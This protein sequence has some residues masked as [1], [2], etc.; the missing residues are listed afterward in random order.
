MK[1]ESY[2]DL[3]VWQRGID[4]V[5]RI[6]RLTATLPNEE[7]YGLSSQ[8]QRASVSIPANIAEGWAREHLGDYLRHLSF[9]KASLAEVETLLII[10]IN[11]EYIAA[12]RIDELQNDL[13]ILGKKLTTLHRKLKLKHPNA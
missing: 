7:R 2:K 9:A 3:E 13:A 1:I 11:L 10:C 6:Y 5:T 12:S 8:L 4:V